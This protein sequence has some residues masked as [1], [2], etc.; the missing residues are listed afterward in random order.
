MLVVVAVKVVVVVVV[1]V[2][3]IAHAFAVAKK[4]VIDIDWSCRATL[5]SRTAPK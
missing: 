2:V 1:D 4:H 3:V 5:R